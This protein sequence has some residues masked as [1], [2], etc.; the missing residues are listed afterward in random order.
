MHTFMLYAVHIYIVGTI[1]P[2]VYK[3]KE[4]NVMKIKS[5]FI[6]TGIWYTSLQ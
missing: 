2:S 3:T 1:S 4:D 5:V 6:T